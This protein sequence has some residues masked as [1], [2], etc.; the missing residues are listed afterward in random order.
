VGTNGNPVARIHDIASNVIAPAADENDRAGDW[1]SAS[2]KALADAGLLGLTV[3][4]E[5]GGLGARPSDFVA[6]VEELAGACASTAMI[7][8]M[9]AARASCL[10]GA[11]KERGRQDACAPRDAPASSNRR[12]NNDSTNTDGRCRLRSQ[13]G[14]HLG[15]HTR[16]H[17]T[18]PGPEW[19]T[20]C[21]QTMRPRSTR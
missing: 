12:V 13:S 2:L 8:V 5:Q 7:F 17:L 10:H 4:R 14:S 15:R 20:F 9:H 16:T 3:S 6:V 21:S 11:A 18:M 19:T 1:P